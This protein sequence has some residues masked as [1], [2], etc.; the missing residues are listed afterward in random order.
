AA[1]GVRRA[2]RSRD[3]H[4]LRGRGLDRD[5]LGPPVGRSGPHGR[6]D[7][8][9]PARAARVQARTGPG[10]RLAGDGRPRRGRPRRVAATRARR[11]LTL[12]GRGARARLQAL[13]GAGVTA[14]AV[15]GLGEA[16][17]LL[18]ADLLAAGVDVRGHDPG[19]GRDVPGLTRTAEAADAVAGSDVVLSVNTAAVARA[20]AQAALPALS[21]STLYADLNT[22]SPELK[23]ELAEVVGG[24]GAAFADVALLGPVPPR[25]LRTP[26]VAS[27]A[28]AQPFADLLGPLGMPVEVVSE[29]PGDAA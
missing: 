6:A 13:R 28:G 20:A 10:A 21:S 14:V 17:S 12:R 9:P 25:G 29:R 23:R 18:A 22:A 4:G 7:D 19:P 27:G 15:L 1:R 24:S 3:R 8:A 26:T 5:P 2:R 16:G 11:A